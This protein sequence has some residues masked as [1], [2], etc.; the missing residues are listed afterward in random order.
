[1]PRGKYLND[2]EKIQIRI[3]HEE[4]YSARSIG[5]KLGRSNTV[6]SNFLKKGKDYGNKK[7]TK[8]NTKLTKRQ[9]GKIKQAARK[10]LN[11]SQIVA[12]LDLPVGAHQ[13]AYILR[14]SKEF[15][16]RKASSKPRLTPKH[17]EARLAFARAHMSWTREWD[18]IIF[19]DEKKFNL[20][21]PDCYSC[22]WHKLDDTVAIRSKRNFGGGSLMVWAGFWKS[23]VLPICFISTRMNSNDYISLLDDVLI[24]FLDERDDEDFTFMQDNASIHASKATLGWL[25]EKQ[26]SV[27]PWPAC[28]P[29]LNPI[30]NLWGILA[31][32]IYGNGKQY[33]TV[34]ELKYAIKEAWATVERSTLESLINSMPNRIFSVIQVN[35]AQT[36]Y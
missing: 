33:R 21:G 7:K 2:E 3:Y 11:S 32:K 5:T 22:Y 35:G 23:G 17:K 20:D 30:E 4:G 6:I 16:W 25:K 27:M 14:K 13:V 12:E 19:S 34:L 31:A 1:M 24:S 18:K 9:I 26:I 10:H 15:Q 36:K 8:G 28:S 29:D